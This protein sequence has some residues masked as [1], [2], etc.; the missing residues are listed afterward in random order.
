[1]INH[2]NHIG[3][4]SSGDSR[5]RA[6]G[7][8]I[9]DIGGYRI[10]TFTSSGVFEVTHG[11]G[12]VEVLVV[13][14]GGGSARSTYGYGGGGGG[15]IL[16]HPGYYVTAGGI[17][18]TV[19][20]GLPDQ[21]GQNSYFGSLTAFGGGRCD[22]SNNVNSRAGGCGG[23]AG[24]MNPAG[25]GGPSIQTSNNGGIGYG[26]AGGASRYSDPYYQG[27]GGGAGGAGSI[28][29]AGGVGKAFSISG[30][31]VYYA[32]GGGQCNHNP[33]TVTAGGTGGGGTNG[34]GFA[35]TG[36]GAGGGKGTYLAYSGGSG[37]VIARYLVT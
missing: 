28:G 33:G 10:H 36:G 2:L 35:N 20:L 22:T 19:G 34:N 18:V 31:S 24:H 13:G 32:G 1:M 5:L 26:C 37:I 12:L 6:S 9:A 30:S 7:G 16:Y 29:G 25:G 14:A 27:S 8:N 23:G 15:G 11:K 4:R 3:V 17:I 21:N